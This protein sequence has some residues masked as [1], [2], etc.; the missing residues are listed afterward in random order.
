LESMITNIKGSEI[1]LD[2]ALR[3]HKKILITSSSEIY[4]KNTDGPLKEGDDRILGSPLKSRWS[5]STSK[6]IDEIL[7]YIYYKER[8]L[9]T[10][11]VRLFNIV[12]PRQTGSY[13]MVI[14]RLIEQALK[15]E[16]LTVYGSGK[17]SR[18][19]LYVKDAVEGFINL[20]ENSKATGEV[21]NLGSEE[22]IEIEDLAKKI[23]KITNSKS[24]IVHVPYEQAYEQGFEEM[25]RRLPDISKINNLIGFRPRIKLDEIIKIM[26]SYYKS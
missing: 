5:Y 21:F 3:Y 20:I 11:I 1:V 22:E 2:M 26:C 7:A 16:P 19:F 15:N 12:G 8:N 14:P 23:I 24:K 18:C 10:I 6:A 25:L 9:P 4:G 17:Q 13:G